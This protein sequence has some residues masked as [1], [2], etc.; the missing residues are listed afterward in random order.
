MEHDARRRSA[1]RD[2]LRPGRAGLLLGALALVLVTAGLARA[3]DA[4]LRLDH[5]EDF[6]LVDLVAEDLVDDDVRAALRS[7][8]PARVTVRIELWEERGLLWDRVV[9]GY[10]SELRL[11]HR[12]LDERYDLFDENGERLLSSPDVE[13]AVLWVET[14]RGLPLCALDR[15]EPG[16]D[17]YVAAH[18]R[19]DPLTVEEIEDLRRWLRG[20]LADAEDDRGTLERL[21]GHLLGVLKSQVGLGD[22]SRETRSGSFD[23]EGLPGEEG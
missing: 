7:G 14:V 18:I 15:L 17:Y 11:V 9:L 20:G 16:K 23:V 19:L 8:L 22:R 10:R 21:S 13:E 6:L 3:D 12:L 4:V 2:V 5:D 1:R